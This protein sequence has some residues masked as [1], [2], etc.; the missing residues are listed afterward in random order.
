M[1]L[2]YFVRKFK[3]KKGMV[4]HTL[5]VIMVE[6]LKIMHLKI[7]VMILA[8]SINFHH[9]GLHKKMELLRERIGQFKKWLGPC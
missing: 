7:F 8:L 4:L 3:M 2:Q 1:F 5:G 9:R 6:S